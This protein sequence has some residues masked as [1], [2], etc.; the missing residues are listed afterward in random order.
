MA[1]PSGH[2]GDVRAVTGDLQ[3]HGDQRA[4]HDRGGDAGADADADA[5]GRGRGDDADSRDDVDAD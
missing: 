1:D 3:G 4:V 2:I 5:G